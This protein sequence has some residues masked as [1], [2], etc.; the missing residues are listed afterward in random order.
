MG[1]WLAKDAAGLGGADSNFYSYARSDPI[2]YVDFNG[3]FSCGTIWVATASSAAG[4]AV[5]G[6]IG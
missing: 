5:V 1:T 6:S 3:R 4:T 2:N